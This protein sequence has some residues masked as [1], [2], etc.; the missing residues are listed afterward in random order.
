MN[1]F[2]RIL[3][4]L[5]LAAA[6]AGAAPPPETPPLRF[7]PDKILVGFQPGTPGTEIA[8]AHA[9]AGARVLRTLDAIGVQVLSVPAGTVPEQVAFYER[10]PNVRYAEPSYLRPLIIPNEGQEPAPYNFSYFDEQYGLHNTGQAMVDPDT[11]AIG[12]VRGTFDADIDWAEATDVSDG[13]GITIAV[14]DS[15]VQCSH[16]DLQAKCVEQLSFLSDGV[17]EDDVGHGTHVAGIAAATTN[18]GTGVAGSGFN[19]LIASLKVC[20]AD[21]L[22]GGVCDDAAIIEAILYAADQGY[23]ILNMSFGSPDFSQALQDATTYAWNSGALPISSAGNAYSSAAGYPAALQEVIAVAAT[24]WHDNLTYFSNFGSWVD[25]AAPGRNILSTYP[26]AACGLT[27]GDPEGCYTWMSGTSMAS[28]HVA[29]VAALV[30]AV[31]GGTNVQVRGWIEST[32]DVT[33]AL[34]QNMRAWTAHGRINAYAAVLAAQGGSEPP[35]PEGGITL[36]AMGYKLKGVKTAD[37]VWSGASTTEV[38]IYRDGAPLAIT[39][40]DGEHTDDI[41]EKGGGGPYTY[42]V[43]ETDSGGCSNEVTVSF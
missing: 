29:G 32:A 35:P 34:G 9:T 13:S 16:V 28:P 39:A 15:G 38:Q 42:Q 7:A 21:L 4:A 18:N 1:T 23:Q 2:A 27:P 12:A 26:D 33:G 25:V 5:L 43:C 30:W 31:S 20:Y 11:G 41:G 36:T 37:L 6:S 40:N 17:H 22:Y 8:A 10:N 14:I 19:A 24:D 3:I